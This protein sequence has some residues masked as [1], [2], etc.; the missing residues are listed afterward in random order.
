MQAIALAL[1]QKLFINFTCYRWRLSVFFDFSTNHLSTSTYIVYV[2]W[3]TCSHTHSQV[4]HR[5]VFNSS[6]K[7]MHIV[8][9]QRILFFISQKRR[10]SWVSKLV[11]LH[12]HL[13][14]FLHTWSELILVLSAQL[15]MLALLWCFAL[16]M[17]QRLGFFQDGDSA[18][19]KIRTS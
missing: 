6:K 7:Y 8:E 15:R 3:H 11:S 12:L 17:I 19:S 18:I 16:E 13:L 9:Y 5:Y 4:L 10:G 14:L 2:H 1:N